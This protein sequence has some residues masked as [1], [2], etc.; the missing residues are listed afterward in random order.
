VDPHKTF[1]CGSTRGPT[2][3]FFTL[4]FNVVL[5]A[6]KA[7]EQKA[8]DAKDAN[9]K[10]SKLVRFIIIFFGLSVIFVFKQHQIDSLTEVGSK[11]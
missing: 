11:I 4:C 5:D 7:E 6:K 2:Q 8:K 1:S 10:T 3:N 9:K